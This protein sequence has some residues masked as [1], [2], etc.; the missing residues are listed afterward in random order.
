MHSILLGI[1]KAFSTLDLAD[2]GEDSNNT[3]SGL[4]SVWGTDL[5]RFFSERAGLMVTS[6]T[7]GQAALDLLNK[8]Q[9]PPQLIVA[10]CMLPYINGFQILESIKKEQSISD[11]LD[12][13]L[14]SF[15]EN[16]VKN[17]LEENNAKS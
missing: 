17:F 4:I 14:G 3:S 10:E 11:E 8:L 15:V 16:I 13:K 6:V 12:K 2:D 5:L 7:S 9:Y 1:G